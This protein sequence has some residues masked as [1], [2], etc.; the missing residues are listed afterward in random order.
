[1]G[2]E[3][4]R[5][6]FEY[7][8][9]TLRLNTNLWHNGRPLHDFIIVSQYLGNFSL[10]AVFFSWYISICYIEILCQILVKFYIAFRIEDFAYLRFCLV[11]RARDFFGV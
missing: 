5:A 4:R 8:G 7:I 2:P 3:T 9:L 6:R 10:F 1:M 11:V